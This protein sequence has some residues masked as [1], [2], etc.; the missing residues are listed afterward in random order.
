MVEGLLA[1]KWSV[2]FSNIFWHYCL[3]FS[4]FKALHCII[5]ISLNFQEENLEKASL[6]T[7]GKVASEKWVN[8]FDTIP[9][10]KQCPLKLSLVFDMLHEINTEINIIGLRIP[11]GRRQTSWLFVSVAQKLNSGLLRTTS[12]GGQNEI[13]TQ[14]LRISNSAL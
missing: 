3:Y 6:Y 11:S 12:A 7:L 9:R 1:T 4:G 14:D 2:K 5:T 10:L 8:H 13:W